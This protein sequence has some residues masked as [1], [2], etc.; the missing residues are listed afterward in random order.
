MNTH[1]QLL[2]IL[3][4]SESASAYVA[5]KRLGDVGLDLS[6]GRIVGGDELT[7]LDNDSTRDFKLHSAYP[8]P[9]G[10]PRLI[11]ACL[12]YLTNNIPASH[13]SALDQH[14]SRHRR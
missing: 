1:R 6:M 2:E 13:T 9:R 8:L 11:S 12:D 10:D 4:A 5:D 14:T 3:V 7:L